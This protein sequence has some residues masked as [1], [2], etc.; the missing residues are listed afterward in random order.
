[1]IGLRVGYV[2]NP[3]YH[4]MAWDADDAPAGYGPHDVFHGPYLRLA[5][6]GG[7]YGPPDDHCRRHHD[8]DRDYVHSEKKHREKKVET[9][10][11]IKDGTGEVKDDEKKAA[12][13]GADTLQAPLK[14]EEKKDAPAGAEKKDG[15]EKREETKPP[16][17]KQP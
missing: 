2:I 14:K 17:K 1:M 3:M 7:G 6:G 11:G 10:A 15:T 16:E 5:I 9:K 4:D 12:P 8:Q 13:T